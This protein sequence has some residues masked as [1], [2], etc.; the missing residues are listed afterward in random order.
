MRRFGGERFERALMMLSGKNQEEVPLE[1]KMF[2]RFVESAQK[3]VEGFNFDRRK[4]V[5]EYDEVLRKQRE[6]IYGQRKDILF[7]DN[8]EPQI[9][10]M[11]DSIIDRYI[12]QYVVSEKKKARI[13]VEKFFEE[14]VNKF[15]NLNTFEESDFEDETPEQVKEMIKEQFLANLQEKKDIVPQEVYQEFLK[16]ILLRSVDKYWMDH[17]DQ[18]SS[19]RQSIGLQSYA[20][21]NPLREYQNIGFEMFETMVANIEEEVV[22][23]VSRAQLRDNLQREEVAKPTGTSGGSEETSKRKPVVNKNTKVGRND[24]CPCGSGK[25]YK[26]CCGMNS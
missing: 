13:D 6:I 19:L 24:P 16:V 4:S 5:V 12:D 8:M 14:F 9:E 22:I 15:F 25:K 3:K 10:S 23:F 1:S 21:I 2:S 18:M 20:Q 26:H 7:L 17:I 11:M